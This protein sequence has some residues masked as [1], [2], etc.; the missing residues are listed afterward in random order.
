MSP[1]KYTTM[2]LTRSACDDDITR[3]KLKVHTA[4]LILVGTQTVTDGS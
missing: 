2:F 3:K 4:F 1:L